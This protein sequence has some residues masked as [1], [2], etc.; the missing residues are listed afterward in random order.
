MLAVNIINSLVRTLFSKNQ[1][2]H[3]SVRVFSGDLTVLANAMEHRVSFIADA[4]F[5]AIVKLCT[6]VPNH[7]SVSLAAAD[8]NFAADITGKLVYVNMKTAPRVR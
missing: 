4:A 5:A 3:E 6:A 2:N 1:N 7:A 8:N